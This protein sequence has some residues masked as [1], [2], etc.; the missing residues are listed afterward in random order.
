MLES[1][2]RTSPEVAAE[3]RRKIML[4]EDL[5]AM[6]DRD[7]SILVPVIKTED[8]AA[9]FGD[10]PEAVKGKVE[11]QMA[12]KTRAMLQQAMKYGKPSRE[13]IDKVHEDIVA[14]A[15]KLV[16]EGRISDPLENAGRALLEGK[17]EPQ[18]AQPVPGV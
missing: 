1:L 11:A 4:I 16:R 9:A 5:A 17:A 15:L 8:W 10:L 3:L 7:L 13:K 18:G 14:A 12:E 2:G 6:S